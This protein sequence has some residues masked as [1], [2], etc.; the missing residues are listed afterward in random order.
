MAERKSGDRT[1]QRQRERLSPHVA[2]QLREMIITGQ[3]RGGERLRAEH[4]ADDLGVSATPVREALMSM[5]GEGMVDFQPGRGFRVVPLTRRD[6]LDVY[7]MQAYVSGKLA[8]LA[9]P[10]LTED[11]IETLDNYQEKLVGAVAANDAEL[12]EAMDFETHRLIN[13]AAGAPKLAWMLGLT[14][15]YVPFGAHAEVPGWPLAARD[16]HVSIM[17]AL[18]M[19]SPVAARDFMQ[20]HIHHAGDLLVGM[21]AERGV[22]ED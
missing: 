8:E 21:L 7:D 12:I 11:D 19:R 2:K 15:R 16:D 3:L 5:T 22:L 13:R 10:N 17:R 14:L 6:V 9:V 4:L 20:A 1:P 18:K